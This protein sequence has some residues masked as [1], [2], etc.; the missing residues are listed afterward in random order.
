MNSERKLRSE[1]TLSFKTREA[2]ETVFDGNL[3]E[4]AKE[5]KLE[6]LFKLQVLETATNNFDISK[7][8]GQGGF[9]AVYRVTLLD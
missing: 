9:G 8:L 1:E 3:P 7:K 6:P 5:V 4:N 2:Q